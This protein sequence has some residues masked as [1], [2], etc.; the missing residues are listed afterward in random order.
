MAKPE[1]I[2]NVPG[3]QY[4][5]MIGLADDM[6]YNIVLYGSPK[7]LV[8]CCCII[9]FGQWVRNKLFFVI[10]DLILHTTNAGRIK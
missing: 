1:A 8:M 3:M 4:E 10:A 5:V 9:P 7:H 6:H 2:R